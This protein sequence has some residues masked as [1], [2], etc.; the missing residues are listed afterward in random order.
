MSDFEAMREKHRRDSMMT[1]SF[2]LALL[3][4]FLFHTEYGR[5]LC[6]L[7]QN[8]AMLEEVL[9][10]SWPVLV[11]PVIVPVASYLVGIL[12][13]SRRDLYYVVD[14]V[15]FRRRKKVDRFICESMLDFTIS[16]TDQDKEGIEGLKRH[17]DQDDKVRQ[18]MTI[19]YRYIEKS[20]VVNATL[21]QH[22]FSHW[23]DYFSRMMLVS[24]GVL[25]LVGA[26]AIVALDRS[27][28][29]VRVVVV[30]VMAIVVVPNLVGLFRGR[31]VEK[32]YEIPK[33]QIS[34][35]HR[36]AAQSVLNELRAEGF[37]LHGD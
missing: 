37:F 2:F 34:E 6:R 13:I 35:I 4:V 25:A 3:L 7:L 10:T 16:L 11:M 8:P 20:H 19:F 9:K 5:A 27:V 14:D 23:G 24:W 26:G 15:V 36:N 12:T 32:Q 30:A 28:S 22:A 29:P 31:T 1:L 17:L 18:I 21:K 33:T